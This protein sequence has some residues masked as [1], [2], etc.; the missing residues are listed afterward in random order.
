MEGPLVYGELQVRTKNLRAL[1]NSPYLFTEDGILAA[2]RVRDSIVEIPGEMVR[3]GVHGRYQ[4]RVENPESPHH[5]GSQRGHWFS[6]H[7]YWARGNPRRDSGRP[8]SAT[9]YRE[10]GRARVASQSAHLLSTAPGVTTLWNGGRP[11][12]PND[13]P[14]PCSWWRLSLVTVI[15]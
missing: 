15:F 10:W 3:R 2:R 4:F 5:R 11:I 9:S 7:R 12:S 1:S 14:H 13:D 6:S 8:T